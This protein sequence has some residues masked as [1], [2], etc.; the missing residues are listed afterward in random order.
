MRHGRGLTV[1]LTAAMLS[2]GLTG[3]GE[4]QIPD[5]TDENML[6]LH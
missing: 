6:R 2:L 3:C 1:L 5:L 4:N